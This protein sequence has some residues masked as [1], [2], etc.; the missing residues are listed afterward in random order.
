MDGGQAPQRL[1]REFPAVV[2]PKTTTGQTKILSCGIIGKPKR[3]DQ[4]PM[5]L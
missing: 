4:E 2:I 1:W 5:A 3:L